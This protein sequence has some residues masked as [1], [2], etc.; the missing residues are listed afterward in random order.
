[1]ARRVSPLRGLAL[2]IVKRTN[3]EL[4][5][6]E[7]EAAA[8]RVS[9][10]VSQEP[11]WQPDAVVGIGR[12]GA[13]RAG[14]LA[15]NLGSLPVGVIDAVYD[16]GASGTT[17]QL[18]CLEEWLLAVRART[19]IGRLLVVEGATARGTSFMEF[20]EALK[21]IPELRATARYAVLFRGST[22][23]FDVHFVGDEL[24]E[25]PDRF[26]WHATAAYRR[27]TTNR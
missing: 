6:L 13:I 4:T 8:Q 11:G 2:W 5:W 24:A 17:T 25:W 10:Q 12:S 3:S 18:P 22:C 14:W 26:P 16:Q 7:A 1:M 23:L 21:R 9:D 19:N 15:G 27:M 20:D